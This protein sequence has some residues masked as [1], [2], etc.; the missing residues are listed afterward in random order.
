M[1]IGKGSQSNKNKNKNKKTKKKCFLLRLL[2]KF[3]QF[4]K[5]HNNTWQNWERIKRIK[6]KKF[7]NNFFLVFCVSNEKQIEGK[8][9]N[10]FFLIFNS[11][12]N[13]LR[14]NWWNEFLWKNQFMVVW[15]E[16]KTY[17]FSFYHW[18]KKISI[19]KILKIFF[20]ALKLEKYWVSIF[21]CI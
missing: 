4:V 18:F 2:K 7:N 16:H 15:N 12:N 3:S 1:Y 19:C 17:Y 5:S 11:K 14:E 6:K 21:T 9:L 8:I 10:I 13:T 20:I